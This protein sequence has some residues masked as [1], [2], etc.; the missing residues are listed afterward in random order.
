MVPSLARGRFHAVDGIGKL[1]AHHSREI[2]MQDSS[3]TGIAFLADH[4]QDTLLGWRGIGILLQ[5]LR[6]GFF[7]GIQQ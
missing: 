3:P 2:S 5:D 1:F 4:L 6:D 7:V